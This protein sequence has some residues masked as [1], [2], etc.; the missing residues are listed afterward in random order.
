[1]EIT[2]LSVGVLQTN[3]YIV[4]TQGQTLLID[5]GDE[6]K[7]IIYSLRKV[8]GIPFS[9]VLTHGHFDHIMGMYGMRPGP[10]SVYM[11]PDDEE[12]LRDPAINGGK[13]M[14]D[15]KV[16]L[17]RPIVP[18]SEGDTIASF[19]VLHTPGHSK[20]SICLYS[21]KD[22]L[23]FSG[24]TMFKEGYGRLD[25]HGASVDSMVLSMRKLL[26]LPENTVVYPGHGEP[27]TI[28]DER[29]CYRR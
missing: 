28:K 2:R 6:H 8:K 3:C 9:V 26:A 20:G 5:P 22:K 29:W 12:M 13:Q 17:S 10:V 4:Q 19:T 7:R 24:D 1:M 27:T 18:V 15:L 21:E 25:L 11:H 23:L 16:H 14:M